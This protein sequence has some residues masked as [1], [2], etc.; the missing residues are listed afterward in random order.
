MKI[1]SYLKLAAELARNKKDRRNHCLGAVAIRGD[2]AIVKAYNGSNH[3]PE[4]LIHCEARLVRKLD[5]NSTVF[6]ARTTKDGLWANS[7][8]CAD[9]MRAL[10]RVKVKKLYYTIGPNE[11]GTIMFKELNE[12]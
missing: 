1:K 6:L 12:S 11:F 10:R 9:C 2:G 7:R 5:F 4:P 3:Y 8:P